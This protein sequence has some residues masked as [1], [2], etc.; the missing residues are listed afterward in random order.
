MLKYC[1]CETKIYLEI[2]GDFDF[3]VSMVDLYGYN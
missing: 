1:C 2:K 3:S